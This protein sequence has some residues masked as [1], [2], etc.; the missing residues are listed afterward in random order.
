MSLGEGGRPGRGDRSAG[1]PP[2]TALHQPL[3]GGHPP[4]TRQTIPPPRA[5]L[6]FVMGEGELG[7]GTQ[8]RTGQRSP[9]FAFVW[10][11]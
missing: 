2:R 5:P 6:W 1:P 4:R 3:L 8:T 9:G 10:N 7:S 11:G